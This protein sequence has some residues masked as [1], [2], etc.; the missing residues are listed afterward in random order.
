M[1]IGKPS[2]AKGK[3]ILAYILCTALI[4]TMLPAA[5]GSTVFAETGTTTNTAKTFSDIEN[6]WAK[7]IIEEAASK[8][9][10]GGYPDG[11][12]K[13]DNLMKR[14]EFFKLIVNIL[15]AK[16]V[17]TDDTLKTFA[18]FGDVYPDEWYVDTLKQAVA[19]GITQGNT[20][21]SFGV[22]MMITRQEAA[23]VI[24]SIVSDTSAM[25]PEQISAG[26]SKY[27]NLKDTAKI[28]EWAKAHVQ[29]VVVKGYVQG[30]TE[31][32]FN[33]TNALTRA[34]AATLI[35]NVVKS[36]SVIVGPNQTRPEAPQ[37]TGPAVAT[38][39]AVA[40]GA[41]FTTKTG[42][43][44]IKFPSTERVSTSKLVGCEHSGDG[45]FE[46]GSGRRSDPYVISTEEQLDHL[47][48]HAT[49]GEYF[50][51]DGNIKIRDD[52]ATKAERNETDWTAGNF[53]P[54]GTS[55]AP[56]DGTLDGN[57]YT[58]S[59]LNI[60]GDGDYA[61]LF[62]AIGTDG[63]VTNLT[64]DD[65]EISAN[66]FV[67]AITGMNEGTVEYCT[68]GD[69][70][71]VNGNYSVGGIVGYSKAHLENNVNKADVTGK[72]TGTGGIAG[73][74]LI[75]DGGIKNCINEGSVTGNQ[76]TGGIVGSATG[77][78]KTMLIEYCTNKGKITSTESYA[79]GIIGEV[80]TGS[81][82]ITVSYC[83][84]DGTVEGV[85]V[86]AGIAGLIA[87][88]NTVT[89]CYNTGSVGGNGAG[90]VAGDN[91]GTVVL[92]LNA[93]SVTGKNYAGGIAALQQEGDA[94][95]ERCAN[96]GK[97]SADNSAG[98]IVGDNE[99]RIRNC[100]NTG[101]VYAKTYSGGI[102]GRNNGRISVVY[103]IGDITSDMAAGQLAG[104]ER[105]T[106]EYGF[107]PQAN[108]EKAAGQS[109]TNRAQTGLKALTPAQLKNTDSILMSGLVDDIFVKV[110]NGY[111]E[112]ELWEMTADYAY[113]ALKG[114]TL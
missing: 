65:S 31:G 106:T 56:F 9:I 19:A 18:T 8:G 68:A 66:Q 82:D 114:M 70:T 80:S 41:S 88:D 13:P 10:V 60:K 61:G 57:G 39:T 102:A 76:K 98:G 105:A 53:V 51:L 45:A 63:T 36:E 81:G 11:T 20:Y 58:I 42:A 22:G 43:S 107:W 100:Y 17:V 109:D 29:K 46:Y 86:N 85:G 55:K 104:L 83:R 44:T 27:N 1:K 7:S 2:L 71:S 112:K 78:S 32:N 101:R 16:P 94:L 74:V 92:C 48:Q 87:K 75:R 52:F 90:G 77:Y 93:G 97:V 62:A 67:G 5:F 59:G 12:Y 108:G 33:P 89:Y 30:D 14:E 113:P 24:S 34:E 99:K 23:K 84:N 96:D 28:D 69:Y 15:T 64:I 54:I 6:H 73:A 26:Q 95:I 72:R 103:S 37:T 110:L 35:L 47:R 3:K 38:N 111:A 4:V 25:T 79:G 50:I 49:E 91:E 40:T 21:Y